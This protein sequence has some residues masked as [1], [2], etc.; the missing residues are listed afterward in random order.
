MREIL[1]LAVPGGMLFTA[2]AY[3]LSE[4]L[5]PDAIGMGIGMLLGVLA[6]V[7]SAALVLVAMRGGGQAP[8]QD[9]RDTIDVRPMPMAGMP[10]LPERSTDAEQIVA[11][12][13][14][15]AHLEGGADAAAPRTY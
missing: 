4:R 12:R 6:G 3:Y 10:A 7:P 2:V 13:A 8:A 11:L 5:S 9:Y 14:Y 15:L 1:L